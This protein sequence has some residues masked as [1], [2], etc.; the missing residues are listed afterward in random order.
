[1]KEYAQ[2]KKVE[3]LFHEALARDAVSRIDFLAIEC[4]GDVA[5]MAEVA[6]LL[7]SFEHDQDFLQRPAFQ[8]SASEV[9]GT[10]LN[11]ERRA[12]RDAPSVTGFELVRE[13]GRGGMGAVYE[14]RPTDCEPE[15]RVA[16]KVVKR[17]MDTDFI[18][19]RFERER[20]IMAEL[21]HP[22]IARIRDGGTTE[23]GLPY[24]V[25]EY[26][27]G[28]PIDRYAALA[29]LSTRDRLEVFLKVCDAV[30]YAHSQRIIHR[31]LKP[32]NILVTDSGVPKLLDFG[33]AKLVDLD[34]DGR[35]GDRTS[36]MH[37]VM[38]PRH[39]SPEQLSGRPPTE[40]SDVYS[41]GVLLYMLLTGEHPYEFP[42]HLPDGILRSLETR[43]ARK[44]SDAVTDSLAPTRNTSE[45]RRELK[46]NLDTIVLKALRPEPERRY[47]SVERLAR[48]IRLHLAGRKITARRDSVVYEAKK[49]L[50]RHRA[51]ALPI[52]A[53][54]V[55]CLLLGL[56]LG[57]SGT[58][59]KQ[60]TSVAVMP[61][62]GG[63]EGSYSEQLA[64]GLS[65]GLTEQLSRLPQL[66]VPTH[67][68][69]F[70]YKGRPIDTKA[71][72]QSLGVEALLTGRMA[73]DD[74]QLT[75]QVELQD[76]GSGEIIWARNYASKPSDLLVLQ[77]QIIADVIQRLG[78]TDS[79]ELNES[80]RQQTTNEEA[81]R[82]YLQGRYFFNKRR[83]EDFYKGIEYFRAATE[84][85]PQYALAYAG[86]A[87]SYG[88]LG[89]YLLLAP[90]DAFD[91]ARAAANKALAIDQNLAEAHASLA[92]VH[93][94]YDWDW[95]AA[96]REFRKAIELKPGYVIAHHWRGLFLGEMG[97]FAEAEA[98]MKRAVALDPVSVPVHADYARV[99]FWARR[100]EESLAMYHKVAEMG[101]DFGSF[102]IEAKQCYEQMGRLAE[103]E[104]FQEKSGGFDPEE[105]KA[106]RADGFR[107]YWMLQYRRSGRRPGGTDGAEIA[108]RV[109]DVDKAIRDLEGAISIR[110]HRMTQLKVNPLFHPLRS[111]A[112]FAQLLS[113]MNLLE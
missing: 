41:L 65:Y 34:F 8:Q 109:G 89:A 69:V 16:I 64:E 35:P 100:Y 3:N 37:R 7:T 58:R 84:K 102:H 6:S 20:R 47:D 15:L 99:L 110:D 14:G 63:S 11:S 28:Q 17:G 49:F 85:D 30:S 97:R 54:G 86:L 50:R 62:S 96:D 87:D 38:T 9:A 43:S 19:R 107:G 40:A 27:E 32:S 56:L 53:A 88:L 12:L 18:L 81:Y 113:R 101:D 67:N 45:V 83:N 66:S 51:Y 60:R 22:F 80:A 52:A 68:S 25:M 21:E 31:D 33:I 108:A 36:T 82:L 92:L 74:Q 77:R 70:R 29:E 1:M 61:F 44:P 48:D 94:L 75:V 71:A 24:F 13:I 98:E 73:L 26:V 90:D 5:V 103:W 39:A 95:T 78:V 4:R 104:A 105:R 57:L 93:W 106:F 111:D 23:S 76:S 112:R 10:I 55:F 72:G 46:G 79:R 91:R 42:D 59:V 2:S